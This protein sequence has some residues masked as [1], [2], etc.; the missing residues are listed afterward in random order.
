MSQTQGSFCIQLDETLLND[1][2]KRAAFQAA[3]NAHARETQAYIDQLAQ[4]LGVSAGCAA[5]VYYL[6]TRARHTPELEAEL[7]HLHQLGT[8]PNLLSFGVTEQTQL[9]LLKAVNSLT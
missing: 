1:P 5:D 4:E 2:E 3:M 7:I 6:R 9:N 8:P